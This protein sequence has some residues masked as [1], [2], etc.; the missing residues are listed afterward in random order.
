M[1]YRFIHLECQEQENIC[2]VYVS[3]G[4]RVSCHG[5]EIK[6]PADVYNKVDAISLEQVDKLA[7]EPNTVVISCEMD[8]K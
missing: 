6:I 7:H 2:H 5:T 1:R 4:H 3:G 8:L